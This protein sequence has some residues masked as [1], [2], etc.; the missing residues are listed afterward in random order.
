MAVHLPHSPSHLQ[1][2]GALYRLKEHV[3]GLKTHGAI[4]EACDLLGAVARKGVA[5]RR[6]PALAAA[7]VN[8]TDYLLGG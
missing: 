1:D 3:L 8:T 5:S 6:V 7:F 4:E 2:Y